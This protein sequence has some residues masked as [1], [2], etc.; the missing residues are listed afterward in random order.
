MDRPPAPAPQS[1]EQR[2]GL[3]LRGN[4]FLIPTPAL[5]SLNTEDIHLFTT[6]SVAEAC[7][8]STLWFVLAWGVLFPCVFDDLSPYLRESFEVWCYPHPSP[9]S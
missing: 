1:R 3:E 5:I 4:G 2:V 9:R 8:L 7:A 6:C